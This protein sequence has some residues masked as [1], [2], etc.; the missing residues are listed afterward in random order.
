[1]LCKNI[2]VSWIGTTDLKLMGSTEQPGPTENILSHRSFEE[3]YLLHNSASET[4]STFIEHIES[5]YPISVF[6]MFAQVTDP[7]HFESIYNALD[8]V[9]ADI[10]HKQ[11]KA[12]VTL[13]ITS[14]TSSMTAVSILLG[15]AKYGTQFIQASKEQGVAEPDIPFEIAADYLPTSDNNEMGSLLKL[16]VGEAPDTAKFDDIFTQSDE[17]H[18]LKQKAAII[19]KREV[20]V[21]IYGETGTGKELFANAIHNSSARSDKPML[22]L[23]CGAIPQELID[24]TLFGHIKGAFTGAVSN[25]DGYFKRADGGTLFLDEFGELPLDS[26]VR[27]LRVLQQGTYTPVG[28]TSEKQ[29]DVRI[30]AA[31]NKDLPTLIS[32]GRFREDLFYRVAI[33]VIHL[34]PL[35]ERTGDLIYIA[36]ALLER[37]NLDGNL[38]ADYKHKKLSASAINIML[39]HNWPGNVRELQATLLRA[40]LWQPTEII[41]EDDI[42]NALIKHPVKKADILSKDVSQGID[43]NELIGELAQ[44]YFT[45]ALEY[46]HGNKTKAAS[47]LGL[48]NYQTLNNWIEKYDIN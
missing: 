9:L 47:L 39:N 44:H 40:T 12:K 29:V 13:Q 46:S 23:N 1:M 32:Q 24:T 19:A 31:T 17:M 42:K 5:N 2:L 41:N 14:G 38:D 18:L 27:L 26:Q 3:V 4:I 28:S 25:Q 37:I 6:P 10:K 16:F 35:R 33:G 30:I 34:P 21:L 11:P 20:P 43:I 48:K 36:K 8:T 7:T 22:T 15:K 45:K